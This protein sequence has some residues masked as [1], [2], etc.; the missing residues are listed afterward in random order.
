[1]CVIYKHNYKGVDNVNLEE[2]KLLTDIVKLI[3]SK[4]KEGFVFEGEVNK[5]L[6]KYIFTDDSIEEIYKMF[7]DNNIT[8]IPD[9]Q[10]DEDISD[11]NEV[12]EESLNVDYVMNE[13][14]LKRYLREMGSISMISQEEEVALAIRIKQGDLSARQRL[15]DA[16]LRL[17]V[18]FAK[19]YSNRGIPLIDLIQEGNLGLLKAVERY[20]HTK[21]FKFSTYAT[22]WIRQAI[23]RAIAE[24]SKTIR[25][26]MHIIERTSQYLKSYN[27]L[28]E[29][30]NREP[31]IGELAVDMGMPEEQVMNIILLTKDTLSLDNPIGDD[32]SST[33]GDLIKDSKT[34]SPESNI[35]NEMLL[36]ELKEVLDTLDERERKIIMYRFGV[37]GCEQKTLDQ[38]GEMFGIT[39]E[40]IRQIENK[41]LRKLRHPSRS[42][43]IIDFLN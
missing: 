14:S 31:T 4:K 7:T 37:L 42:R 38:V 43:K 9:D 13:D 32:N 5:I 24:Q 12:L 26:P 10:E 39:R 3:N 41:A 16:N 36:K 17:V 30:L 33:L 11:V 15:I 25:I 2:K 21:G 1:M 28:V 35:Y 19:K 34:N 8:I 6:S 18:H 40:R 20:D 27:R 22:W 29:Q 23:T